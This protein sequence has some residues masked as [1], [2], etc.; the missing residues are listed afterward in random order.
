M[1][2]SLTYPGGDTSGRLQWVAMNNISQ[3][4]ALDGTGYYMYA[5]DSFGY[6]V[7]VVPPSSQRSGRGFN[8]VAKN[9][10][11]NPP[12]GSSPE[13]API[14]VTIVP[15]AVRTKPSDVFFDCGQDHDSFEGKYYY[16]CKPHASV[17]IDNFTLEGWLAT[18]SPS[19]PNCLG[20]LC[21]E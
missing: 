19:Y 5:L 3:R 4:E 1:N 12:P 11:N 9:V 2:I 7:I 6:T 8:I 13:S 21:W 18:D 17:V 14:T 16:N 15:K 20:T 10:S